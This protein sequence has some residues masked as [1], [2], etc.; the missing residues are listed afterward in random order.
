M[1]LDGDAAGRARIALAP[2][3]GPRERAGGPSLGGGAQLAPPERVANRPFGHAHFLRRLA[4]R[5]PLP[6]QLRHALAL[7]GG[8]AMGP[9]R[10]PLAIHDPQHALGRELAVLAVERAAIDREGGTE[11]ILPC[12]PQ[13]H[14]LHRRNALPHRIVVGMHEQ[15]HARGEIR[16]LPALVHPRH[17]RVDLLG[18]A[19]LHRQVELRGHPR[20]PRSD[21]LIITRPR[22]EVK[23]I[24][25]LT[26]PCQES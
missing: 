19:R 3:A 17:H 26:S 15:G 1:P 6:E 4:D 10:P 13:G 12:Q 25:C 8:E 24:R 16:D 5:H 21:A 18:P 2:L 7:V 20:P 9:A 14:H 23:K 11:L 22:R